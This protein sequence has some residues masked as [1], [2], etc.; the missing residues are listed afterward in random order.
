MKQGKTKIKL[1]GE[2][3][4]FEQNLTLLE[5][6]SEMGLHEKSVFIEYN[7]EPLDRKNYARTRINEGDVIEI[8]TMMAGG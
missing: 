4:E 2:T 6:L 5:L 1:N 3:R 8:V 7:R